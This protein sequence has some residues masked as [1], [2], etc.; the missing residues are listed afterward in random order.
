MGAV[1]RPAQR[2]VP[3]PLPPRQRPVQRPVQRAVQRAQ[4]IFDH[5]VELFSNRSTTYSCALKITYDGA[6]YTVLTQ[7]D[8]VLKDIVQNPEAITRVVLTMYTGNYTSYLEID[9]DLVDRTYRVYSSKPSADMKND[10][11][12][13]P[14]QKFGFVHKPDLHVPYQQL[15][16]MV[17]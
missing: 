3:P 8:R 17:N 10:S 1:Q 5:F 2:P 9:A 6:T 4:T 16:L 11:A 7:R 12:T 15:R 13:L 14:L